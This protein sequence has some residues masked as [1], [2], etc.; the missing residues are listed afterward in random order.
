VQVGP[1]ARSRGINLFGPSLAGQAARAA[2]RGLDPRRLV[3]NPVMLVIEVAA[4]LMTILVV[5]SLLVADPS[6]ATF[7]GQAAAWLWLTVFLASFAEAMAEAR[8]RTRAGR[9]RALGGE[10]PAKLLVMPHDPQL[11]WAYEAAS[12]HALR[13]G[14]IVLVEAGHTIPAD[15]EVI[16]GVAEVDESAITGESTPVIRNCR[17]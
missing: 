9:L 8:G 1:R 2:L 3:A 5:S 7:T 6:L 17:R 12:S 10:V 16:E 4:F 15:G 13:A 11:T 14:D